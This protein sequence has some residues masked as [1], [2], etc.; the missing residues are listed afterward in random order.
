MVKGFGT[1]NEEVKLGSS[2]AIGSLV[3][4]LNEAMDIEKIIIDA[5]QYSDK[6][7]ELKVT[8]SDGQ[9]KTLGVTGTNQELVFEFEANNVTT[10]KV[11]TTNN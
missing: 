5:S 4:T 2:K 1:G 9:T 10:I 3:F 7:T 8:L 6:T 11:E